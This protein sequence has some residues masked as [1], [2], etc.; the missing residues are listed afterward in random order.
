MEI[1][2]FGAIFVAVFFVVYKFLTKQSDNI[3]NKVADPKPCSG[4]KSSHACQHSNLGKAS[5]AGKPSN[6][7]F[8]QYLSDY[9]VRR[10]ECDY[11]LS[12]GCAN[13]MCN[14]SNH[15]DGVTYCDY[16]DCNVTPSDSCPD[17]LDYF[18]TPDGSAFL[19]RM[20]EENKKGNI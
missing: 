16:Y 20:I 7:T 6:M 11:F 15:H 18:D 14:H 3:P 1:I 4:C 10:D 9:V 5:K 2:L 8:C 12:R 19:N 17:Y 13:G